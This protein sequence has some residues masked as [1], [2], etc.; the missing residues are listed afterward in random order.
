MVAELRD[1]VAEQIGKFARPKHIV[2]A[3]DLPKTAPERSC[4]ASCA[5]SS[6]AAS[7]VT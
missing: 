5:M 6:R 7:S 1:H 2:W 4:A 3:Q